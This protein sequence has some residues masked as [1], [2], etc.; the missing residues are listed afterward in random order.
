MPKKKDESQEPEKQA[1]APPPWS[2]Q[3]LPSQINYEGARAASGVL[4]SEQESDE[5]QAEAREVTQEQTEQAAEPKDALEA[6]Q[7]EKG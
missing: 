2:A 1:E 6:E 3:Q 5:Q 4:P 7:A